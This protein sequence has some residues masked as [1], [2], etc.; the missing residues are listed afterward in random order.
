M[1]VGNSKIETQDFP[2]SSVEDVKTE[3]N[4]ALKSILVS[5][6]QYVLF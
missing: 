4:I 1:R 2:V 3:T 6:N 5:Q